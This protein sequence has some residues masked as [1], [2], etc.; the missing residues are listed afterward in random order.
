VLDQLGKYLENLGINPAY[1]TAGVAGA[2]VHS[3]IIKGNSVFEAVSKAVV[4]TFCAIYL[5][6]LFVQWMGLDTA[7]MTTT[8]A[9]AFGIGVLG[10]SLAEGAIRM[11]QNWSVNPRLPEEVSMKGFAGAVN[12]PSP[13]TPPIAIPEEEKPELVKVPVRRTRRNLE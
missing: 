10:M 4:G 1:L 7:L 3:L 9:V 2:V 13:P 5:T 8:N 6:P 11:A 12:P